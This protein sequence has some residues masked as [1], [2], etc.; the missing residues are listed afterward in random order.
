[1]HVNRDGWYGWIGIGGSTM[2]WHPELNIG[3]GY[4]TSNLYCVDFF[5]H[6]VGE[7]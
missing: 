2:Q 4:A 3:F 1:M 7:M 5:N 6:R